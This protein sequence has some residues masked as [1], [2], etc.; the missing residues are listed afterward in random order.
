MIFRNDDFDPRYKIEMVRRVHEMFNDR[1]LIETI[2]VQISRNGHIGHKPEIIRYVR[3]HP[4]YD[5]ALHGWDH[6]EYHKMELGDILKSLAASLYLTEQQFGVRPKV[7]YPPWNGDSKELRL[8]CHML[9]LEYSNKATYIIHYLKE[10]KRY[11]KTPA[12][13]FHMW[14]QHNLDALP[15]LLDL[16]KKT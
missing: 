7:F 13:Y 3:T 5:I 14:E 12:I 2:C 10:P 15:K 11:K 4:E 9:E 1:G 16:F 8:A 6:E